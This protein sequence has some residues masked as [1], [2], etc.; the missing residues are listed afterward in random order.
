MLLQVILYGDGDDIFLQNQ[1][2]DESSHVISS[3]AIR[4][5]LP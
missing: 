4:L 1:K 5:H 2:D 3:N